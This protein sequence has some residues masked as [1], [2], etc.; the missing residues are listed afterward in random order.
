MSALLAALHDTDWGVRRQAAGG[1]GQVG[2]GNEAVMSALLQ[3]LHDTDWGVRRR[4]A[5]S[6]GGWSGQRGGDECP[7]GGPARYRQGCAR[8]A[9]GGLGKLAVGNEAVVSALLAALHDT[10]K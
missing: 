4:A 10:D 9:A 5:A 2:V 6:L 8:R 7:A 1:L 3:A